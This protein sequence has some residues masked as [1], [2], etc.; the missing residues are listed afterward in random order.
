MVEQQWGDDADDSA[1]DPAYCACM[2]P[3]LAHCH[4]HA[5][6]SAT[7]VPDDAASWKTKGCQ[8]MNL[9][10]GLCCLHRLTHRAWRAVQGRGY[11]RQVGRSGGV[12]CSL[13][14]TQLRVRRP[15]PPPSWLCTQWDGAIRT[16]LANALTN[17]TLAASAS[18]LG[19]V[20][21]VACV[22]PA[23]CAAT[24]CAVPG[25]MRRIGKPHQTG[26]R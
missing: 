10:A 24:H 20:A 15:P 4:E 26:P 5:R 17:A 11:L 16:S 6:R 13:R 22:S 19:M 1:L 7:C 9:Q 12:R 25:P 18:T 14:A 23:P 2:A 8:M 3:L 21:C